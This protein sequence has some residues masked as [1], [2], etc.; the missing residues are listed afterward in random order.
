MS[1]RRD[2]PFLR[3][4]AVQ[5]RPLSEDDV[6]HILGWVN[7]PSIV[8]NIAAFAGEPFTYEQELA[9]VRSQMA[10]ETDRVFSIF[11][12]GECGDY[13]GQ[14]GLHQIHWRSRV[15]RLGIM[16]AARDRMGQGLGSAAIAHTLDRA[17]AEPLSLHKVWLMVFEENARSLR[18]YRRLGFVDEGVLRE[19]Y[20][21]ED[22]WH[23]MV[24]LSMLAHEW[25]GAG[26]PTAEAAED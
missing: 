26:A 21:H 16:M 8:G 12:P 24:R 18:T 11:A 10:S 4:E 17:F 19:E 2:A 14:V 6:D 7:D 22:G 3:R 20:F 23:N 9:Y 15:G 25:A 13:L 1:A 5:L